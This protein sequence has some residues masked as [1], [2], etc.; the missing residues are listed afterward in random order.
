[1]KISK[2]LLSSSLISLCLYAGI[3]AAAT[4]P[5]HFAKGTNSSTVKGEVKGSGTE[6]YVLRT[7]G[8]QTMSV[9]LS[10]KS[11][12]IHFNVLKKAADKAIFEGSTAKK[13]DW[14]GSLAEGGDY[15]VRVYSTGKG[16]EAGH[17][18]PFSLNFSIK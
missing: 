11:A 14:S 6:E 10:T 12:S 18:T 4:H 1:M 15:I 8:G 2:I 9:K 13:N 3:T 7:A 5:V 17:S 16:Q